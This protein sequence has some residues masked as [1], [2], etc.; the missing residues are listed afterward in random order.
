MGAKLLSFNVSWTNTNIQAFGGLVD[1]VVRS[2]HV[3][4]EAIRVLESFSYLDSV[5]HTNGVSDHEVIRR[6]VL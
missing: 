1:D 4:G 6:I 2:V 3:C 5:I